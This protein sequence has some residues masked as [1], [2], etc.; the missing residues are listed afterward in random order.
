[1]IT[2]VRKEVVSHEQ[3]RQKEK[4]LFSFDDPTTLTADFCKALY[5]ELRADPLWARRS[6]LLTVYELN[7]MKGRDVEHPLSFGKTRGKD[8]DLVAFSERDKEAA[9]RLFRNWMA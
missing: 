7:V 9:Y 6:N 5:K 2:A 4:T 1:M 3:Q 8:K